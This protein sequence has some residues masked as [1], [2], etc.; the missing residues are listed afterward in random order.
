MSKQEVISILGNDFTDIYIGDFQG[1]ETK[2][3]LYSDEIYNLE[4]IMKND[5]VHGKEL[6]KKKG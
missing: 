2:K 6:T 1:N 4:I 3:I 5:M